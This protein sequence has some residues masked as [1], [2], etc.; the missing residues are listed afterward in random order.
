MPLNGT[1]ALAYEP[2]IAGRRDVEMLREAF[3]TEGI[4]TFGPRALRDDVFHALVTEARTQRRHAAWRL[5]R[6]DTEKGLGEETIRAHLGPRTRELTAAAATRALMQAVTGLVTE[7]GWGATCLT[8]YERAG[9]FLGPH[10]DK[11]YECGVA[12]LL[13]LETETLPGRACGPGMQL[14]VFSGSVPHEVKM[15]ITARPNRIVILHGS[16]FSHG[17]PPLGEGERVVLLSACHRI[18]Q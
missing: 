16:R 1:A 12:L 9:E 4:A 7:P 5:S 3:R 13:Y 18:L 17:R 2:Y 6:P 14:H 8:Y 10:L 15:R 11:P